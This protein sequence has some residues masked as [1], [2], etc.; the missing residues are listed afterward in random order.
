LWSAFT[1]LS[2]IPSNHKWFRNL[3]I[4][5]IVV[6]HLEGSDMKMRG[7]SVD[8]EHIGANITRRRKRS[9]SWRAGPLGRGGLASRQSLLREGSVWLTHMDKRVNR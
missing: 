2:R 4:A 6:D 9:N 7:P 8:L 1:T 5:R 3:A